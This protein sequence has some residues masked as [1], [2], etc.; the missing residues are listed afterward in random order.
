MTSCSPALR[1]AA[2]LLLAMPLASLA[3][4]DDEPL[5]MRY[6]E[7]V[8]PGAQPQGSA[9]RPVA[10]AQLTDGCT[11]YVTQIEDLRAYPE[12]VGNVSFAMPGPLATPLFMQSIRGAD[13]RAWVAEALKTLS[14]RGFQIQVGAA[15]RTLAPRQAA[16]SVGLQLAHTW[17]AGLNLM[18]HVVLR[19]RHPQ[20]GAE[21]MR[22]YHG[23]GAKLNWANGNGE[24]MSTLNLAMNDALLAFAR[25]A[26]SLCAGRGLTAQAGGGG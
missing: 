22:T 13:G 21:E 8:Q 2:A 10:A 26:A 24:F 16:V 17:S 6:E 11:L 23:Q 7:P 4:T 12:Y 5:S 20:G 18:S 1:V 15:P 14:T 25:D 3:L 9:A 19:A